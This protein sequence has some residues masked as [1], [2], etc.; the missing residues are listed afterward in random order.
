MIESAQ[1][2]EVR[3]YLSLTRHVYTGMPF[4]MSKKTW[5]GMSRPRQRMV[6][7]AA[8]EAKRSSA[9]RRWPE[10]PAIEGLKRPCR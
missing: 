9:R 2:A 1:V 5:D 8:E 10:E 6:R 4:L 7:E 3:K